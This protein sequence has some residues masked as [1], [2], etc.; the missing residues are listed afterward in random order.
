[1][2]MTEQDPTNFISG[3]ILVV[4]HAWYGDLI[5]GTFRLA[6]EFA[7][8]LAAAGHDVDYVCCATSH[9]GPF[10]ERERING[11]TVHRYPALRRR[12]WPVG[13]MLHHIRH[14]A[15]IVE[16]LAGEHTYG[17][18]SGHSPLQSR[19]A[20]KVM[21]RRQPQAWLNYTVHSPFDDEMVANAKRPLARRQVARVASWI[22]CRNLGMADRVQT[23]SQYTLNVLKRKHPRQVADKGRVAPGWVDFAPYAQVRRENP[24]GRSTRPSGTSDAPIFFTLR[25]LETRM[26][27]ETLIDASA[28]LRDRGLPFQV[29]IGGNGSL[30]ESL[31]QQVR[32]LSLT[33]RVQFIGRVTEPDLPL[34]Y[35]AADC[36]ILPTRALE[37][38]GLIVLEAFAAGTP[39]IASQAAAIPELADRQGPGW[40]FEPGDA[41]GLAQRMEAFLKGE[42]RPSVD[43]QQIASEFDRPRLF[44]QWRTL[45][46]R[47]RPAAAV[48]LPKG[49]R[50]SQS[51]QPVNMDAVAR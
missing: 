51:L 36:F 3:R 35:A 20:F 2:N 39:V 8:D 33:D 17:A 42:L 43:L 14:T 7:E 25:R 28:L 47:D 9:E 24:P 12:S 30:R 19:G 41:R 34:R 40:D 44:P 48:P 13:R 23:C 37:C 38:F 27:L 6:S 15:R 50:S 5:G 31:E 18:V 46:G 22:D 21:R 32:R 10:P 1:V 49:N 45:L 16:R 29:V 4:A 26:G 11:L